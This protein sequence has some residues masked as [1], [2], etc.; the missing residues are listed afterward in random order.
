[1]AIFPDEIKTF[2]YKVNLQSVVLA[3][4]VNQVYDEVTSIE[5][6]L[7]QGGVNTSLTWGQGAFNTSKTSWTNLRERLQNLENGTYRAYQERLLAGGGSTVVITSPSVVGLSITGHATQTA[8]LIE[9]KN[10]SGTRIASVSPTGTLYAV[11]INGG[12]A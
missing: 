1:M 6:H 5:S 7:G 2:N 8:N 3:E 4:D 11:S 10:S 12:T 9:F